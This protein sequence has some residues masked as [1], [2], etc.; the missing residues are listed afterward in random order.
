[1]NSDGRSLGSVEVDGPAGGPWRPGSLDRALGD[2]TNV[3]PANGTDRVES[4]GRRDSGG[5]AR[6]R[7]GP[8][9]WPGVTTAGR[10]RADDVVAAVRERLAAGGVAVAQ[11]ARWLV[12]AATGADGVVD[13][14]WLDRAVE[15]RVGGEPLQ[16]VIGQTAF[17]HVTVACRSGVFV[18]RP[19]TEV[20]AGV[21]IEAALAWPAAD[22]RVLDLCTGTGAITLAVASE[23]PG[24]DVLAVERDAAAVDL[25]RDNVARLAGRTSPDPWRVGDHPAPGATAFV[26]AGDLFEPVPDAWRGRLA[27]LVANPPYLP[28]TDRGTWS[29]EVADHDPDAALVGGTDGHEVV[30]A[31]LTAAPTWLAP[32]GTVVV[33]L[34]E[35]RADDA[36]AVATTAG[37]ANAH[38]VPDLAGRPRAVVATAPP[39]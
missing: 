22:R 20:V 39:T 25:A 32:G 1:M 8:G 29:V 11:E 3:G 16:V 9:G 10:H 38:V 6:A 13:G 36:V 17:R 14:G 31:I 19:E 15:R 33:E 35:R 23:V 28:T 26:V 18:P 4:S 21:A 12:E 34:D 7:G 2:A 24:A 27:V 37:L 5:A 30:D